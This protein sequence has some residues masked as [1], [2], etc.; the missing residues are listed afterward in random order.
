M[1]NEWSALR[2]AIPTA[3]SDSFLL[4]LLAAASL[5]LYFAIARLPGDIRV[6]E[7]PSWLIGSFG[8]LTLLYLG[9]SWL[10]WRYP[11]RTAGAWPLIFGAALLFRLVLAP[12]APTAS[13]DVYRYVWDG[14]VQRAGINPYAYPPEAPELASL[15]DD[16]IYPQVN[17]PWA[18]TVY[19]PAAEAFF[20]LLGRLAP[21]SLLAVKLAVALCD[22]GAAALLALTLCR[23]G[24]PAERVLLYAWHPLVVFEFAHSGHIDALGLLFLAA[25]GLAHA[26]RR[27]GWTGA[28]LGLATLVKLHPA[29]LLP[30]F[31][32]RGDW[33]LPVAFAATIGLSYLPYLG[34]GPRIVGFLPTYLQEEGYTSGARYLWLTLLAPLVAIPPPVYMA[35]GVLLLL[36]LA[37]YLVRAWRPDDPP[38]LAWRR[39]A[40]LLGAA[41]FLATPTYPWYYTWLA[42]WLPLAPALVLFWLTLAAFPTYAAAWLL[43]SARYLAAARYLPAALLA[44]PSWVGRRWRAPTPSPSP[45]RGR[46]ESDMGA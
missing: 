21:D 37:V 18:L 7:G 41:F 39:A 25:A 11:A 22:L 44:V 6:G 46:G 10:V 15:R 38:I 35:A 23:L 36:G 4:V 17:R 26:H 29:A 5:P 42:F 24:V 16:A 20:A 9:A 40:L 32:R 43:G 27:Q 8:G 12:M 3:K 1:R 45:M 34:V 33:R 14:R 28:L 31:W 19:P 30:A 13:D 2:R